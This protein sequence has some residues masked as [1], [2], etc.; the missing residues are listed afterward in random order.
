[1]SQTSTSRAVSVARHRVS[2]IVLRRTMFAV[3]CDGRRVPGDA[4]SIA[5]YVSRLEA[6]VEVSAVRSG[7]TNRGT[8]TSS[9]KW[10][11]DP[12]CSRDLSA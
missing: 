8:R 6:E 3:H 1:M 4:A 7:E 10:M 11:T 12:S 2:H 9:S 5:A